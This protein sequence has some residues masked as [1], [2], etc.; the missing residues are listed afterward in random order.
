VELPGALEQL[1]HEEARPVL[2]FGI[3]ALL[4]VAMFSVSGLP[5][6]FFV[7]FNSIKPDNVRLVTRDFDT[8][9]IS[10]ISVVSAH[11]CIEIGYQETGTDKISVSY[12]QPDWLNYELSAG[13]S[14]ISFYEHSNGRLPF[15]NIETMHESRTYIKVLIPKG[16]SPDIIQL[17]SRGGFINIKGLAGNIKVKTYTGKI[18][19]YAPGSEINLEAVTETGISRLTGRMPRTKRRTAWNTIDMWIRIKPSNL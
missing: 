9:G 5:Y 2:A 15:F 12:E 4:G 19:L 11:S 6:D 13:G 8:Q 3:I 10:R 18:G 17:E 7:I 16:F 14:M 1:E